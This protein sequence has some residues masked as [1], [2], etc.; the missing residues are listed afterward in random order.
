MKPSVANASIESEI[1]KPGGE[2]ATPG[3]GK[4]GVAMASAA[5]PLIDKPGGEGATPGKIVSPVNERR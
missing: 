1:D 4:G 5:E 2:G 3:S